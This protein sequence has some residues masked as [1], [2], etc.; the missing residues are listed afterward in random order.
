MAARTIPICTPKS[1]KSMIWSA[2]GDDTHYNNMIF[3]GFQIQG[4]WESLHRGSGEGFSYIIV[5]IFLYHKRRLSLCQKKVVRCWWRWWRLP[6]WG[7]QDQEQGRNRAGAGLS[8]VKQSR[9]ER[10]QELGRSWGG[11]NTC[12]IFVATTSEKRKKK[13]VKSMNTWLNFIKSINR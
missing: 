3:G 13:M 10:V 6:N 4:S 12:H 9:E 11:A 2:C 1:R 7:G 5:I 8:R